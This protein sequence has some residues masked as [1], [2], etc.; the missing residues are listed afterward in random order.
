VL[1]GATGAGSVRAIA[2]DAAGEVVADERVEV[3][4]DRGAVLDLPEDT[5]LLSL[6]MNGTTIGGS[7]VATGDG[8]AVLRVRALERSGLI[9]D[10]RPGLP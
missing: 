8:S 3:A 1:G 2:R 5:V 10:V 4:A 6:T 7:V 9:A